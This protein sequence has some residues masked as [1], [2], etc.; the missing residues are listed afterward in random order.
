MKGDFVMRLWRFAL[1]LTVFAVA[2]QAGSIS[3]TYLEI[4]ANLYSSASGGDFPNAYNSNVASV[5]DSETYSD[6]SYMASLTTNLI[7]NGSGGFTYNG[8]LTI[9]YTGVDVTCTNAGGCDSSDIDWYIDWTQSDYTGQPGSWT[10]SMTG[11]GPSVEM[12]YAFF[13]PGASGQAFSPTVSSPYT[14]TNSGTFAG[15]SSQDFEFHGSIQ[16][17]A[18]N[19]GQSINL[20]GSVELTLTEESSSSVPEPAT[21]GALMS[22]LMALGSVR[23]R[24][25][26][27]KSR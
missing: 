9:D 15:N 23:Y 6:W 20:P 25:R 4:F 11:T 1:I 18:M 17:P 10:L 7:S 14:Y 8:P 21:L 19:D 22:G 13:L 27:T 5:S 16:L 24:F 12:D 2:A 26:K 3:G